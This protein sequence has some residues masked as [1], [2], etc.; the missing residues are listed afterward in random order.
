MEAVGQLTGGIA[1]DFNNLLTVVIGNLQLVEGALEG[2]DK[3]LKR[4]REAIEA[5][6][7]GSEL[8]KQ[9]LAFARRQSLAPQEL[10][11][12]ELIGQMGGI[13]QRS[14]GEAVQLK[15]DL[16][17]GQPLIKADP[18]QLETSILN[19]AINARDAMKEKGGGRLTIETSKVYL[20]R[21]YATE[22]EEVDAGDYLMIAVSDTGDGIPKH[23]YCTRS[24]SR[25]SRPRKWARA[26]GLACRWYS[27]SSSSPAVT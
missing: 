1:H 27:A 11:V 9:L 6:T 4:A 18:T 23:L 24:S 25:S 10:K 15:I 21:E 19:L 13:L 20:D 3:A 2:N 8:T 12:N 7:K 26:P 22:H 14:V 5:A 17:D 16:M